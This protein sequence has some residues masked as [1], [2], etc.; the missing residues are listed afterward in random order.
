[1][2][3]RLVHELAAERGQDPD[4]VIVQLREWIDSDLGSNE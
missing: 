2:V 4:D 3:K 1:M